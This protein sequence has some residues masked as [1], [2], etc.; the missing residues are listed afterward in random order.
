MFE[1]RTGGEMQGSTA[2]DLDH[3]KVNF[4][5]NC[6]EISLGQVLRTPAM[7]V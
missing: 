1:V 3:S 4:V 5:R 6:L 2:T 7:S